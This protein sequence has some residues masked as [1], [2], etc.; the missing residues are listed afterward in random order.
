MHA[1]HRCNKSVYKRPNTLYLTLTN[2][3]YSATRFISLY[4]LA[5]AT[6]RLGEGVR[7]SYWLIRWEDIGRFN[8][9]TSNKLNVVLAGLDEAGENTTMEH[10]RQRIYRACWIE[11]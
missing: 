4:V 9:A 5:N 1:C 7:G 10:H 3:G 8:G 2:A 6:K 11:Q